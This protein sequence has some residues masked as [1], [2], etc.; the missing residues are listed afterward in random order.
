MISYP[1]IL[2]ELLPA[3]NASSYTDLVFWTQE[4]LLEF[5]EE[6]ARQLGALGVNVSRDDLAVY[7]G[8]SS[9]QMP[10]RTL[11]VIHVSHEGRS[12]RGIN[13]QELEA[14][15]SDWRTAADDEPTHFAS[16]VAGVEILTLYP[17]PNDDGTGGVVRHHWQGPVWSPL[18]PDSPLALI[19]DTAPGPGIFGDYIRYRVIEKARER[20]GDGMML[21]AAIHAGERCKLYA[22]IFGRYWEAAE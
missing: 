8:S 9:F 13:V 6:A 11:S 19:S 17:M 20:D 3:L 7:G 18:A 4:E 2:E 14:R 15:D 10:A 22:A 21:D 12:L 1:D 5:A 16:D